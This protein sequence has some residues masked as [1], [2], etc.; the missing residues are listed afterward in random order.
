[1]LF[2]VRLLP[3]YFSHIGH[4]A[5]QVGEEHYA[6]KPAAIGL[7]VR[8]II[9]VTLC[10]ILHL[11]AIHKRFNDCSIKS[12][13]TL[14][15]ERIRTKRKRGPNIASLEP[16]RKRQQP[17]RLEEQEMTPGSRCRNVLHR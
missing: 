8:L 9:I 1:M 3:E 16:E 17:E 5:D 12:V 6:I 7:I 2:S 4:H 11:L 14:P 13:S 15:K 10:L